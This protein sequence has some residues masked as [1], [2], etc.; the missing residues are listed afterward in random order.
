[1]KATAGHCYLGAHRWIVSLRVWHRGRTLLHVEKSRT[2]KLGDKKTGWGKQ[3]RHTQ[4]KMQ[5]LAVE[6]NAGGLRRERALRRARAMQ[7]RKATH[8][9]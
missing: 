6:I 2:R 8:D 7:A 5:A 1:M 3:Y 9:A 4:E